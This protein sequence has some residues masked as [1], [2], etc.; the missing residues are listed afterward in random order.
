MSLTP[1]EK[2]RYDRHIVLQEVGI[3]GQE[4]IKAASVLV[5]GAGG[6][7]SPVLYYLAAAGIGHIGI[8]DDDTVSESN[9]QRQ[10]LYDTTCVGSPKA[11][12]AA[13]KLNRLNPFC[14]ITP[15]TARLSRDNAPG[16]IS[17]YDIVIDATDN[18]YARYL[19][20]DACVESGKPFVYGSICEFS[21]QLSVF[22]YH[23]GPTYRDL[24]E[25]DDNIVHFTQPSGVIGALPGIIGSLQVNETIKI[26]LEKP[27]VLSGKL[28]TIDILNNTYLT[29]AIHKKEKEEEMSKHLF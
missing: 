1:K 24:F 8:M 10:I 18:L 21:G 16:I 14:Q 5:V 2:E 20:N 17:G 26:I 28:L 11:T 23:D 6:L 27:G 25:Y 29:F 22:N 3:E 4:K 19:I 9:L 12:V 13:D 7:G 15:Y